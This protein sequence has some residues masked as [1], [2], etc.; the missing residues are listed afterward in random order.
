MNRFTTDQ[1]ISA[2]AALRAAGKCT[3]TENEL[4][5]H[6]EKMFPAK[7]DSQVYR[8]DSNVANPDINVEW[9]KNRTDEYDARARK[10][11]RR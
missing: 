1:L 3:P 9:K 2:A 7:N 11:L 6:A 5:E 4:V 8:E 10:E